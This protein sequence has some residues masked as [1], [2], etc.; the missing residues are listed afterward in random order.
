MNTA[1]KVARYH[2]L[3]R[4]SLLIPWAVLTF[5]LAVNL[6]IFHMIPAS[7]DPDPRTGGL[8]TIYVFTFI[9]GLLSMNRMMPFGLALGLSRRSFFSGA[10]LFGLGLAAVNAV[11][12]TLLQVVE[13]ASGGWGENLHFFRV[14]WILYGHWYT[15][16]LTSFVVLS[17]MFLWG[18]W[19]GLVYR[20]WNVPGITAFSA[21]QVAVVVLAALVV[22]W[23]HAWSGVGHFL[24]DL[25]AIGVTGVLALLALALLGGGFS[26]IRRV[27]V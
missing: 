8:A 26:T 22:T 7:S 6:V 18:I 13:R 1:I 5:S 24:A 19:F 21:G 17:L 11:G 27:T 16:W 10:L 20:R 9:G 3:D 25:S 15:T 2:L 4:L 14:P 12:L 23:S